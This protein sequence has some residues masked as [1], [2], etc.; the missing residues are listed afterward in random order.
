LIEFRI[1]GQL[2][3]WAGQTRLRLQG[4]RQ[5]RL[6]AML[7]L[8]A[9]RVV[10]IDRLVTAVWE[11]EPPPTAYHQVQNLATQL[12][13]TLVAAGAGDGV[14]ATERGGYRL[15]VGADGLDAARFDGLVR[16]ARGQRGSDAGAAVAA[17]RAALALW[18]GDT[19]AG[20]HGAAVEAAAA[21]WDERRL[22]VW[23]ECLALEL[24]LG[25]HADLIAE[26]T[27]LASEHPF[28]ERLIELLMI[29]LYRCGRQSEALT[30]YRRLRER[31]A[32]EL[33]IDPS[34]VASRLNDAILRRDPSV[35]LGGGAEVAVRLAGRQPGP[36]AN[37]PPGPPAIGSSGPPRPAQLPAEVA[38]FVGREAEVR[39][40]D[41]WAAQ[42]GPG[43]PV[44]I[45]AITG[46]AG[47]GKTALAVHWAHRVAGSSPSR[48]PGGELYVNLRGFAP[49]E[50][51]MEPAEAVRG[52]L[53]ALGVP[54]QRVPVGLPAQAALY[55]SLLGG[56]RLLVVLDN[57][58]DAEQVRPL[59]P[60][61]PGCL[62]LVTSRDGLS[63][64][65]AVDGA[66]PLPLDLLSAGAATDLLA[67][68]LGAGR[69]A[70]EPD[71]VAEIIARC[72][73]LPL[74]LAIVAARAAARP[75]FGLATLAAEL[76]ETRGGL[77]ALAGGDATVDVRAVLSWSYQTLSPAAAR[78]FRLL[79]LHPGPDIGAAAAAS[80]AGVPPDKARP[81]LA[82]LARAHLVAEPA[83][84]RYAFHDLLRAYA[85]ELGQDADPAA[86]RH[87]ALHRML[88]HYLHTACAATL[89]LN[90]HRD[91]VP[92]TP[93]GPGVTP[94]QLAGSERALAWFDAERQ[95]LTAAVD[96]AA[97]AGFD[98]HAWQLAWALAPILDR[99]GHWQEWIAV[100]TAALGAAGRLA[101]LPG[102]ADAH[103]HLASAHA[104]LGRHEQAHTHYR[105]ALDRYGELG[106]RTGIA[107]THLNLSWVYE[108]Q[109]RPGDGLRQAQQAL[110]IFRA[111]GHR[112]GQAMAVNAVGWFHALLGD[113]G[114]ALAKC[115]QALVLHRE[116]GNRA[117]EA[118]TCDSLG[119]AHHHLGNHREAAACYQQALELVRPTGDSY[120][121]AN[122]LD[123]LGD[124]LHAAAEPEAAGAAWRQS[125][126]ILTGFGHP[127]ADQVRAKLDGLGGE[128]GCTG[129]V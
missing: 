46:T 22:A 26:L 73:R 83:P 121:E 2:Q 108:Q 31:L 104:R 95:A 43:A 107:S 66:H 18:R 20:V 62:A 17:F 42:A 70:A 28:R 106:D 6:L 118:D 57:A 105:H 34:P 127:D 4:A 37:G 100:Q 111:A 80:L 60:G 38:S 85:T 129:S 24:E 91:P 10:P 45:V 8:D 39:Q 11:R 112:A 30:A 93:A 124:A 115:Q 59:L 110:D 119:Y 12:R 32:D 25:R 94:E 61:A 69:L 103:R 88:D 75:G 50:V 92:L 44:V 53:D 126:A 51:A 52:F 116:L 117:G 71:A 96:T 87:D 86:A 29:A 102:Q 15:S 3:V 7:L 33:G 9:G 97:G 54:P 64:L 48:F 77:D 21:S 13:R 125:L 16:S 81:L 72:A 123:H 122:V 41:R 35:G 114:Q 58:R 1:L 89:L 65:V 27:A 101:D 79:G 120:T 36:A 68:R 49:G 47:V 19:L 56:R 98:L 99:H 40:L 14:L 78:L 82:E 90:P 5:E 128:S 74:A 55:R 113:Y 23:E 63:G 76:A 67:R 84:G 109:G